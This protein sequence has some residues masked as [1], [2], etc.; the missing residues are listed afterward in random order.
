MSVVGAVPPLPARG[1]A[2]TVVMATLLVAAAAVAVA[3]ADSASWDPALLAALFGFALVTDL[4]AIETS[5]TTAGTARL[6]MS[7]S[8]I[9]L[10][11]AMVLLGGAPA[12]LIGLATIVVGHLRFRE[13]RDLFLN[14]L[15]AYAWF[16]LL[17]GI[18]F[19][20][21]AP[22]DGDPAYYALVAAVFF[23]ALTVNFLVIVGYGAYLEG[24]RL[25]SKIK[26]TMLPLLGW[27]LIAAA[28][29][30]CVV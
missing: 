10:V 23:L 16:P 13:R 21:L 4:W 29:A 5:A 25:S 24:S 11:V 30:V 8:F 1:R 6:L 28:I 9:A 15:V 7:G 27:D 19:H 12:A 17:G 14:N 22:G 2:V 18:V 20:A 26:Q 3:T